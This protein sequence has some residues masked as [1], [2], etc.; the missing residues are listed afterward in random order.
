MQSKEMKNVNM[1]ESIKKLVKKAD[2]YTD[3]CIT[4]FGSI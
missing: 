1:T 3:S 4:D 2:I